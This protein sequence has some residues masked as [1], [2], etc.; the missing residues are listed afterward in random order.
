MNTELT[1][2]NRLNRV[3]AAVLF[4][5]ALA[6]GQSVW[7]TSTFSVTNEGNVFTVTRSESGTAET[8]IYHTVSLTALAGKHFTAASGKL[9]FAADETSK[10]V[11]VTETAKDAVDKKY[12]FQAVMSRSYRLEV[13]NINGYLLAYQDRIIEFGNDYLYKT[14][15]L[16]NSLQ[17]LVV[18]N[19]DGNFS[20]VDP[21]DI[22]SYLKN[23]V[24]KYIDV[25]YDP[26]TN[27]NHVMSGNYIKIDD[28][29]DYNDKTLCTIPTA[30]AR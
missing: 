28:G 8:V 25:S 27:A 6:T 24:N 20:T 21:N 17:N 22:V 3:L 11:T 18:F 15:Y 13:T 2:S 19:Q 5:A 29:Y 9:T 23:Q 7:A 14:K 12:R 1:L 30:S 4:M 26:S 10:T 16:N